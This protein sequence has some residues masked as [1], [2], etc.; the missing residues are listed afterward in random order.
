MVQCLISFTHE[1]CRKLFILTDMN[2]TVCKFTIIG[3]IKAHLRSPEAAKIAFCAF[4][5]GN[6]EIIRIHHTMRTGNNDRIRLK[7]SDPSADLSIC[8]DGFL[9]PFLITATY[10]RYDHRW[11][12]YHKS[13]D[14]THILSP[15]GCNKYLYLHKTQPFTL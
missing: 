14:Y 5:G 12:R 10:I 4:S 3:L 7:F 13:C 2:Y 11:M 9:Y 1:P 8:V 6:M 15:L